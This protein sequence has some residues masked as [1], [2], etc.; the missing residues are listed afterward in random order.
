M[1]NVT[2]INQ[3]PM[4]A[5]MEL[6]ILLSDWHKPNLR[7][8]KCKHNTLLLAFYIFLCLNWN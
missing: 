7:N 8:N 3:D 2:L 1:V 5:F 4:Y 6:S